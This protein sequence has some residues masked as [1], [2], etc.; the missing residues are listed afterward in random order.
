VL[1]PEHRRKSNYGP[2]VANETFGNLT[3]FRYLD[4]AVGVKVKL[5]LVLN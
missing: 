3:K 1:S 4:M 5:F 2:L